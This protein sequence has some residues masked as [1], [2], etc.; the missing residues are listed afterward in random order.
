ML[1][2]PWFQHC[3]KKCKDDL[4]NFMAV[5]GKRIAADAMVWRKGRGGRKNGAADALRRLCFLLDQANEEFTKARPKGAPSIVDYV[6]ALN[7]ASNVSRG[8]DRRN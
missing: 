4:G 6:D 5:V 3:S 2:S 1:F 7:R 8:M